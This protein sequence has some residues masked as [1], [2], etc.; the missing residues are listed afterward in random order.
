MM[1]QQKINIDI[2]D[3]NPVLNSDSV[4]PIIASITIPDACPA[5]LHGF[6]HRFKTPGRA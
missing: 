5:Y 6:M 1:N 4:N 2:G 3:M